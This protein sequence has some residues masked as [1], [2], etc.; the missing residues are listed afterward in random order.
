MKPAPTNVIY[1][2]G[3]STLGIEEFIHLLTLNEIKFLADVRTVPK[4]RSNP[5]YN[6]DVLPEAL[7]EAEIDYRHFPALG[8]W[9]QPKLEESPNTG[10]RSTSFTYYAD[11]MMTEK[12][13]AGLTE[14]ISLS[15]DR[16]VAIMCAEVLPWRCHRTLISDALTIRG[17]HVMHIMGEKSVH[18][19]TLTP[20]AHVSGTDITYPPQVAQK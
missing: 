6:R 10:W 2:I 16:I 19:H 17:F 5:Q 18:E 13:E 14:L 20:W 4:S 9:R 11:Y 8:G 12:F 15:R 1:T 7:S 3:H